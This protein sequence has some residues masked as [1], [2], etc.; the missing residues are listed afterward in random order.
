MGKKLTVTDTDVAGKTVLLRVDHNVPLRPGTTEISDDIRI[1]A[2]LP[3]I[4]YLIDQRCRIVVCSHLGRPGGRVVKE[5]GM[6]PVS[7]R[8]SEL[9]GQKV[10]LAPDCIGPDVRES[11]HRLSRGSVLMLQNL[12]FHP[13]EEA[14]DPEFAAA[15]VGSMTDIFVNDAFG[16]AHRAHASTEGVTHFVPAA[17][18][19]L[20]ARE[21]EVL[22][23]ALE[24]PE[25]PFAA[26][27]GGA[28]V[29][30]KLAALQNLASRVDTLLVG[31]GMAATF[32][33]ADGI[34]VGDSLVEEELVP[35]AS[36]LMHSASGRGFQ[37]LLPK[38]VLVADAF[39]EDANHKVVEVD[40]IPPKWR[41][42]DIGPESA[43]RFG[44]ALASA[45]TVVWNGPMGVSEWR[46]FAEGTTRITRS[47]AGLAA[48]TTIVG[49]GSTA[50]AVRSL[51][52]DQRMSH[53]STG[54]GACLQ[55]LGGKT[56]P[57]V[58]ALMDAI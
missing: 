10:A 51:G 23:K 42:M 17:A 6:S 53:V 9:L 39:S 14:N 56:L 1:G 55:F 12:R 44:A 11:I 25:R 50:E 18:G 32:L 16:T 24:S 29:S 28:K 57:G 41:I 35:V 49:G 27:L 36:D 19:L 54:G 7:T 26:L 3:T 30:D 21:L 43:S 46:P 38:D 45:K 34:E 5:L 8:L 40:H 15:L 58:A 31:G 13:G 33:K 4:R 2:S 37:L 52:M 22:T 48:T 47:L 20:M